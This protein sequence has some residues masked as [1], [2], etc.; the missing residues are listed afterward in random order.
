MN[1]NA[2]KVINDARELGIEVNE[3]SDNP[4][5]YYIDDNGERVKWDYES[6]FRRVREKIENMS[7]EDV[8][9][10]NEKLREANKTEGGWSGLNIIL[11]KDDEDENR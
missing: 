5:M 6:E 7:Q 4:G 2:D 1:F 10:L 8:E 9:H 3:N 11:P